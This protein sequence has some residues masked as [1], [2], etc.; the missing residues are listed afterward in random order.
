MTDYIK[1]VEPRIYYT[2]WEEYMKLGE[3]ASDM[4]FI[5]TLVDESDEESFSV[6][7]DMTQSKNFSLD[8]KGLTDIAKLDARLKVFVF[9]KA[10]RTAKFIGNIL[11]NLS[12]IEFK[13]LEDYD[14]ALAYARTILE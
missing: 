3:I 14:D 4:E 5:I 1:K 12:K 8:I 10:D 11:K 13:F 2:R 9:I 7:V 6:I